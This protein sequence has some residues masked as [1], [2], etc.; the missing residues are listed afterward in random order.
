MLSEARNEATRRGLA[1]R[2][3][4]RD[5]VNPGLAAGSFD[6]IIS[7]H[8]LWTLREPETALR[9]W[10]ELL[11]PAGRVIAIDGHWFPDAAPPADGQ[12][13]GPFDRYYTRETRA[14]LPWMT[15]RSP[16]PVVAAFERAGFTQ[17]ELR[18]LREVHALALEPPSQDPWYVVVARR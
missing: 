13:P 12:E 14:A 2:F 7:R 5:A 17:V 15:A 1:L 3:E 18:Y 8:L 16:Q 10:R 9:G 4:R 6:A 11:R